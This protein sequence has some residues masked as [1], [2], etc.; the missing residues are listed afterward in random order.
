M[1]FVPHHTLTALSI[2]KMHSTL[3]FFN[4]SCAIALLDCAFLPFIAMLQQKKDEE[5]SQKPDINNQST[6][7]WS[8]LPIIETKYEI[9]PVKKHSTLLF[10]NDLCVMSYLDCAFLPSTAMLKTKLNQ[11][12]QFHSTKITKTDVN[13]QS[14]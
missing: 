13:N 2:K 8:P 14:S 6:R 7:Q 4:D 10:F 9:E 12:Q 5:T 11:C 1:T 3:L